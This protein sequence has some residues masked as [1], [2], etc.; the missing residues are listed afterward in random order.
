MAGREEL[1]DAIAGFGLFADLTQPQLE[2]IVHTFEEVDLRG[3]GSHPSPGP[4]GVGFLRHPR[5]RGGRRGRRPAARATLARGD[6]FGEVSILLGEAPIADI[7]ATRPLRCL[8]LA[9]PEGRGLPRR[10]SAGHVPDAPGAGT[11]TPC[12]EP[13]AELTRPHPPGDY[14]VVV[15]GSGPGGLQVSYSLRAAG[16]RHAVLSADES[17]GGMFR[18]WPFFQRLLSWTKPHAPAT[19]GT[20]RVR[21]LRLEQPA[22]RRG[23]HPAR[24]SRASWTGPRTSRHGPRWRRTWRRSRS[25]PALEIRYGC[26]WTGTR[27]VE[28]PSGPTTGRG[29]SSRRPTASIAP[30]S[31]SS[32]SASPS[33]TRRPGPGWSTPTTT[34]TSGPRTPMPASGSSS[35]AS[36]TPASSWPTGSC[37]GPVSSI[38]ASPSTAQAVGRDEVARRGPGPLRPAVRGPRA[39]R[40]RRPSSTPA[41]EAIER[42]CRRSLRRAPAADRRRRRHDLSVDE[43]ISATGFICPL[44]D[45]ADLGRRDGRA[46]QA[47][48]SDRVVGERQPPGRLLRRHHRPG[49][50]GPA[51]P[52][53]PG[54]LRSRPRRSLQRAGPGR[55]S[56]RDPVRRD[57]GAADGRARGPAWTASR[58]S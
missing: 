18:R 23:G 48:P 39:R 14:P 2:G 57:A 47:A 21:A 17:P 15:I 40:R 27:L 3:G 43:V 31:W 30:R 16:V 42:S 4:D 44:L 6:F 8:V 53:H 50:Q 7:V 13:M 35:S 28:T 10:P 25:G 55:P 51:P 41:I 56:C 45:L 26:R 37:R 49:G 29:S 12:R 5:R 33:R 46:E 22:R 20:R 34:P 58:P 38:L 9:G 24:S 19:R 52:R 54:E 36:R 32:P 1:I 11:A